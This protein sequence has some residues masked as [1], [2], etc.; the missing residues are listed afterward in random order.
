VLPTSQSMPDRCP[1]Y[2]ILVNR[3]QEQSQI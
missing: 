3:K 2:C 1:A